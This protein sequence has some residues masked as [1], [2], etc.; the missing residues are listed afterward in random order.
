TMPKTSNNKEDFLIHLSNLLGDMKPMLPLCCRPAHNC[1]LIF[2]ANKQV[3]WKTKKFT[4]FFLS[5]R[6]SLESDGR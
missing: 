2:Q 3:L 6:I 5:S 1:F 4:L